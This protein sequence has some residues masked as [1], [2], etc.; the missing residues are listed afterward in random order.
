MPIV[1]PGKFTSSRAPSVLT[2][3]AETASVA[4]ARWIS[5]GVRGMS[6]FRRALDD[7]ARGGVDAEGLQRRQAGEIDPPS[8]GLHREIG[9]EI[10][11]EHRPA[12]AGRAHGQFTNHRL[13]PF[14]SVAGADF[15][16]GGAL[17]RD[18]E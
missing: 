10:L 4:A 6:T 3:H 15:G 16:I 13:A 18:G 14:E 17:P 8:A 12:R 1:R 5:S 11:S 7:L 2:S 9:R